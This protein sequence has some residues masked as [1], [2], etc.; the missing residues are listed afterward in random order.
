MTRADL[1]R[2]LRHHKL[3][4]QASVAPDGGPQ[5]AV[6]GLAVSDELELVFDT[7][8]SSRKAANLRRDARIALVYWADA[9]TV[10]L[11]GVVDEPAGDE[12]ARLK[13][14]YFTAFPDGPEREALP[15]ITYFR[16]RPSWI[17]VSEFSGATPKIKVL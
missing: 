12:L 8:G 13:Q 5:A 17:R 3:A 11:E 1:L 2:F 15:D 9:V 4:V 10:Q 16:V 7:L 6:V 14:V